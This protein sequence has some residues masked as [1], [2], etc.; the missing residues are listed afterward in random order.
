MAQEGVL[1][2]DDE[3]I[4]GVICADLGVDGEDSVLSIVENDVFLAFSG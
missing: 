2:V 3:L 1:A 4:A